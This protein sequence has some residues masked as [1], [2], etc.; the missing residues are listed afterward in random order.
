VCPQYSAG[1]N[2]GLR[3][4]TCFTLFIRIIGKRERAERE[5]RE[6]ATGEA[7]R[8][9]RRRC[10]L[11]CCVLSLSKESLAL[12]ENRL[13]FASCIPA[14]WPCDWVG[15]EEKEEEGGAACLIRCARAVGSGLQNGVLQKRSRKKKERKKSS[16]VAKAIIR[17][18]SGPSQRPAKDGPGSHRRLNG[19]LGFA[20][21]PVGGSARAMPG[22]PR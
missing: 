11:T 2:P 22:A 13:S 17:P 7:K 21:R 5:G 10:S 3:S 6:R 4:T 8:R 15:G 1:C 14:M 12:D 9:Q 18:W 20:V 19:R 16:V